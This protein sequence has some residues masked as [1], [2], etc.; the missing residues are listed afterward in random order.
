M[1]VFSRYFASPEHFAQWRLGLYYTDVA[2]CMLSLFFQTNICL[3]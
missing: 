1:F 3:S 2:T